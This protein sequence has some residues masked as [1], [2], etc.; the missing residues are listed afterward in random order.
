MKTISLLAFV[1]MLGFLASC[2]INP[3]SM[4]MTQALQDAKTPADHAKLATHYD[5]AANE[6]QATADE[7]KKLLAQYERNRG[8]YGKQAQNL[9]NHCQGLVR[10]YEQAAAEN[11]MMAEAHRLMSVEPKS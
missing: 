11:R 2:S 10:I 6:M 1:G 7:H 5:E 9:I 8:M 3:H 4:D